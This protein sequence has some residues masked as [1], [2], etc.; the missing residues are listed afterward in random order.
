MTT[1]TRH[2]RLLSVLTLGAFA[3][4][5]C[6]QPGPTVGAP[7]T[8]G[9]SGSAAG[10]PPATAA[11]AQPP[12]TPAPNTPLPPASGCQLNLTV[13]VT[14]NSG[15]VCVNLGGVVT[16]V[17]QGAPE[18]MWRPLALAGDALSPSSGAAPPVI[19]ATTARYNAV[20]A[21]STG[22]SS[23]RPAC[24]PAKPGSLSCNSLQYFHVTVIVR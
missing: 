14:D 15:T 16:A 23:T 18:Q 1:N 9:P 17:L 8:A 6:A 5:A 22:M 11:P 10:S 4:A 21:G 12:A 19:G 7:G 2:V 13:T 24:P 3:L 20:K